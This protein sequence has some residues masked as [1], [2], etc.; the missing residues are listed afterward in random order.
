MKVKCGGGGGTQIFAKGAKIS[1]EISPHYGPWLQMSPTWMVMVRVQS[2]CLLIIFRSSLISG[3]KY[4]KNQNWSEV[5]VGPSACFGCENE[6]NRDY[7]SGTVR[8]CGKTFG[9]KLYAVV[10]SITF[11]YY[12]ALP[13]GYRLQNVVIC[14]S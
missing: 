5:S 1:G 4:F 3:A 14:N 11:S 2:Y 8:S 10:D 6:Q 9:G 12:Y 7:F 13:I